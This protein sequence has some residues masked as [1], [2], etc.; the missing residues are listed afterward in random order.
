M[1]LFEK[2]EIDLLCNGNG[3]ILWVIGKRSDNRYRLTTSSK[4]ALKI[5]HY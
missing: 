3:D 1:S 2:Q 4:T 5:T